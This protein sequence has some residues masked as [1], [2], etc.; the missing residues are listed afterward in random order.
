MKP[1]KLI[2]I[3]FALFGA[4]ILF[5]VVH[6]G[7]FHR[8]S[9]VDES[10]PAMS[11]LAVSHTG[12]Y[13][14]VG[15]VMGTLYDEVKKLGADGGR[16]V[17]I[18]FDSPETVASEKLRA[19]VGQEIFPKNL[20]KVKKLETKYKNMSVPEI[21][22][23]A[24]HFPYKGQLSIIFAVMKAYPVLK[25]ACGD[26]ITSATIEIYDLPNKEIIF[27][28]PLNITRVQQEM[29]LTGTPVE[30]TYPVL[31]STI[32]KTDSL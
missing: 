16:G 29:W 20:V 9:V 11:V 26:S 19:L 13:Q 6:Y 12:P 5:S 31:D 15:P 28:I 23:K 21:Q 25:A 2:G 24:V 7:G 10:F 1:I 22:G 27:I 4:L 3:L 32:A 18:Y 8:V 30:S 17:G 14:N